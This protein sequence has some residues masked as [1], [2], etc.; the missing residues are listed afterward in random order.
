M[1]HSAINHLK[2]KISIYLVNYNYIDSIKLAYLIMDIPDN[3]QI[4]HKIEL[5]YWI[6]RVI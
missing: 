5:S 6:R 3:E 1:R 4:V 2:K